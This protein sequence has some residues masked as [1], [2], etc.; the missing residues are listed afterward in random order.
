M[1]DRLLL[2]LAR[3]IRD[4]LQRQALLGDKNYYGT[5][6][7]TDLTGLGIDL[8]RSAR[9]KEKPRPGQESLKPLRQ[10]IGSIFDTLK[11]QLDLERHA[12]RTLAG[13]SARCCPQLRELPGFAGA[14]LLSRDLDE[15]GT[16]E[17]TTHR[18][19][20]SPE[21]IR[22]FA[23][24]DIAVSIVE[25]EARAFLMDFDRVAVHRSVVVD[26]LG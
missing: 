26:A 15:N 16:V 4:S 18:F 19:R 14:Y 2:D 6:F 24:D 13:V 25:P 8:I 11:G 7:E 1:L 12:G 5:V 23:G 3:R 22:A 21:A 10:I 9:S 17:P 20:D